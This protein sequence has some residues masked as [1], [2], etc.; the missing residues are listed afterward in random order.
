MSAFVTGFKAPLAGFALINQPGVRFHVLMPLLINTLLFTAVIVFGVQSISDLIN[1]LSA[2][3]TW[4]EWVAWLLWP[5]FVVIALA[6]VFF[7]FSIVTNLI[8][9]P[10]NGFLSAA[11]ER[12]LTG[13]Q[14]GEAG[15]QQSIPA[16]IISAL[17]SEL[18]KFLYFAV[19]ALPLLILSFIP[20]IAV[21]APAIWLIFGAWMMAIEYMD[22]PM[23]NRG[24]LFDDIRRELSR[25]RQLALGFGA[26]TLVLTLI[27][28]LNFIVMPVAVAGAT[29]LYL[30]EF[31]SLPER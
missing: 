15:N 11:V 2:Q 16:E 31:Q 13:S 24:L 28:V 14:P 18:R 21:A 8:G 19:R 4:L 5:V 29:R 26:G 10:F 22:Y 7:A 12:H 30:Q 17:R 9:A 3:W 6:V 1:W 27:P 23:G 25:R 20:F